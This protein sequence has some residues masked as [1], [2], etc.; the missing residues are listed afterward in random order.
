[1]KTRMR[2]FT[3]PDEVVSACYFAS[4]GVVIECMWRASGWV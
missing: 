1:M 2:E 3:K 4:T